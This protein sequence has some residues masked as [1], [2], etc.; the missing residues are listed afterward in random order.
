M[1]AMGFQIMAASSEATV[2]FS[3]PGCKRDFKVVFQQLTVKPE[4]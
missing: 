4:T 3:C 1:T 2:F